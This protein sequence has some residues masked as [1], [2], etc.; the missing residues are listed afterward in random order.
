MKKSLLAEGEGAKAIYLVLE[1]SKPATL[2][3]CH[4]LDHHRL[5]L[6]PV[7]IFNRQ[8]A[9]SSIWVKMRHRN[10][11]LCNIQTLAI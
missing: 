3:V 5:R 2:A 11:N 6:L 8:R 1:P 7:E 9:V 4:S 10:K